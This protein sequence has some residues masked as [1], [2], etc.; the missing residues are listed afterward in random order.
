MF[1]K[2]NLGNHFTI[3]SLFA[4]CSEGF[5]GRTVGYGLLHWTQAM[6]LVKD[7]KVAVQ[8]KCTA[9]GQSL[10]LFSASR[11]STTVFIFPDNNAALLYDR[12]C[13]THLHWF[14]EVWTVSGNFADVQCVYLCVMVRFRIVPYC[15]NCERSVMYALHCVFLFLCLSLN[16]T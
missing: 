9:A 13:A 2:E 15:L 3:C 7:H 16:E 8:C 6:S 10:V 12:L 4:H 1:T 5:E 11:A 14:L